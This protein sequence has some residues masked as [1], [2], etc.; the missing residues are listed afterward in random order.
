MVIL[1]EFLQKHYSYGYINSN[2]KASVNKRGED[3]ATVRYVKALSLCLKK[4]LYY[5]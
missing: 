4:I 1:K 3:I 2:E 5:V